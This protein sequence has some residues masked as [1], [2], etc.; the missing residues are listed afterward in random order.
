MHNIYYTY[1]IF[2]S[3]DIMSIYLPF[4]LIFST[5]NTVTNAIIMYVCMYVCM[6]VFMYVCMYVCMYV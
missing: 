2:L 6:Y 4:L 5:S 3:F 1:N